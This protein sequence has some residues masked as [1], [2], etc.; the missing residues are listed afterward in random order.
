[1][2]SCVALDKHEKNS[3]ICLSNADYLFTISCVTGPLLLF[4]EILTGEI[5]E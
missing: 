1:M 5:P 2:G 4:L 3:F